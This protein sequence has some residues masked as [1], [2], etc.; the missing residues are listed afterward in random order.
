MPAP[1]FIVIVLIAATLWAPPIA[2]SA[3]AVRAFTV[4][5]E[6]A[7]ATTVRNAAKSAEHRVQTASRRLLSKT[8][9]SMRLNA[10]P[11]TVLLPEPHRNLFRSHSECSLRSGGSEAWADQQTYVRRVRRLPLR[12]CPPPAVR[13]RRL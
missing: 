12:H 2:P 11:T 5:L 10:A 1:S 13:P 9:Y 6:Q 4:G 7:A 3:S 8:P